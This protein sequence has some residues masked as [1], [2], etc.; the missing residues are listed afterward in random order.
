MATVAFDHLKQWSQMLIWR[1]NTPWLGPCEDSNSVVPPEDDE[2]W[3]FLEV[4]LF[5]FSI[6]YLILCL[7]LKAY[8]EDSGSLLPIAGYNVIALYWHCPDFTSLRS[9]LCKFAGHSEATS[10]TF[11]E[12]RSPDR[13][14]LKS[15]EGSTNPA[16]ES[17]K[18]HWFDRNLHSR[19]TPSCVQDLCAGFLDPVHLL[20]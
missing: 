19:K 8:N 11:D 3:I 10:R 17:E 4:L 14:M 15:D 2:G 6:D 9:S 5:L 20:S 16:K 13:P 12:A 7:S 18:P 1:V